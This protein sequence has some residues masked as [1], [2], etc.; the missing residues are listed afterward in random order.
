MR[1]SVSVLRE[2]L[3]YSASKFSRFN[4]SIS[5]QT[6]KKEFSFFVYFLS[7]QL[8]GR[9]VCVAYTVY[10][11]HIMNGVPAPPRRPIC[12]CEKRKTQDLCSLHDHCFHSWFD[13]FHIVMAFSFSVVIYRFHSHPP[14][15][16]RGEFVFRFFTCVLF[17]SCVV[18]LSSLFPTPFPLPIMAHT[19]A[20]CMMRH[21]VESSNKPIHS[22]LNKKKIKK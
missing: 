3:N 8:F 1:L 7:R 12:T 6:N 4:F 15:H 21:V 10:V 16:S 17:S 19:N 9:Y 18:N 14:L 22:D 13:W 5:K 11:R 2:R 20:L